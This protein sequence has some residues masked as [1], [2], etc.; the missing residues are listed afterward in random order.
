MKILEFKEV[1]RAYLRGVD[2]LHGVSF[3]I[4]PGEVVGLLGARQRRGMHN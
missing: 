1:H 3:S 4:E 2:V